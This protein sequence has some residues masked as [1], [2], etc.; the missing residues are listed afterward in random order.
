MHRRVETV[1]FLDELRVHFGVSVD[2]TL[3]SLGR[4][5]KKLPSGLPIRY[6]P[7]SL[8][9]KEVLKDFDVRDEANRAM[10]LLTRLQNS[11]IAELLL[12]IRAASLLGVE[13]L[14]LQDRHGALFRNVVGGAV[15]HG[16]A[17]EPDASRARKALTTFAESSPNSASPIERERGLMWG[18]ALVR[19]TLETLA[20]QFLLLVAVGRPYDRRRRVI[21]FGY[22]ATLD[23][24][25]GKRGD[26]AL[27]ALALKSYVVELETPGLYAA[28]SFHI[29]IPTP[30]DV[31]V[32]DGRLVRSVRWADRPTQQPFRRQISSSQRAVDRA[33]LYGVS[34]SIAYLRQL[35][36][37]R[38]IEEATAE[39]SFA[40]QPSLLWPVA[41]L[42]TVTFAMFL[43]GLIARWGFDRHSVGDVSALVAVVPAIL[44]AFVVP[45]GHRLV[46]RMYSGV[47]SLVAFSALLSFVAGGTLVID[48]P[49]ELRAAAWSVFAGLTAIAAGA[50]IWAALR[51]RNVVQRPP[52]T[53]IR[54]MRL[55]S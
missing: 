21:K 32:E 3:P 29:E 35:S 4:E 46:R 19:S 40:L 24:P 54:Q 43:F 50:M 18:D 30:D 12:A 41:S 38:M 31:V 23:E 42:I 16:A 15:E 48:L 26:K 13:P 28:E 6:V 10:P 17:P 27:Q 51:S 22:E 52:K 55:L 34:P 36:E 53:G 1:T 39:V 7:L 37:K 33:A 14:D 2:F 8:L 44:A 45:G 47:R 49:F 9:K 5:E 20:T 25:V 11:P